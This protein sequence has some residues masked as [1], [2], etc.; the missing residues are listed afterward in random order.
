MKVVVTECDMLTPYGVGTEA[1]W[2]GLLSNKSALKPVERF[3]V[4]AFN[5]QLGGTVPN[6]GTGGSVVF[7]LLE[8]LF[9]G[10]ENPVPAGAPLLLA[11]T[12]GEVDLIEH[13]VLAGEPGFLPGAL[14]QL[15]EK[16]GRKNIFRRVG[17]AVYYATARLDDPSSTECLR[18]PSA[19]AVEPT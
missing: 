7:Q 1:C 4:S 3:N 2:R 15:L 5:S 6:I 17:E 9:A 18:I 13:A 10:N 14:D 19:C 8:I 11:T 12:T 16:I